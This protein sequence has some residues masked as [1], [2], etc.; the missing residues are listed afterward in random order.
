ML[1]FDGGSLT[2]DGDPLP[3]MVDHDSEPVRSRFGPGY[4]ERMTNEH[5]DQGLP[6]AGHPVGADWAGRP[7]LLIF[8]VNETLSDMSPMGQRFKDV[9][10]PAHLAQTW[11]AGLLRDGFALTAVGVN[12]PFASI[13]AEALRVI[14]DGQPLNR[15]TEDA[16][17]HVME[18][19]AGLPV[20]GD[21]P[22]G[23]RALADA[24]IRLVSLSN[25]STS[26]AEGLFERAGIRSRFEALLSVE[27]AAFWKPSPD[28][29][30]HALRRSGVEPTDAM[31]VAVH[32]WDID[33]AARAGLHSAWI[34]RNG[35]PYPGYFRAP[36]IQVASLAELADELVG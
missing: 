30:A 4:G 9:G 3:L 27:D 16:V 20:H 1:P 17:Q 21:V 11:F 24:G 35:G 15:S 8:D 26:L 12:E 5:A 14:L 23:I 25:G 28:A 6:R 13:A 10:A 32:P 29:Y 19:F 18:G 34:N 33:G 7:S 31:L 36:D 22:Q 2:L